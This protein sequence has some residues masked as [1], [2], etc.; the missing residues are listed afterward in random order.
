M[1]EIFPITVDDLIFDYLV[2]VNY[3][4][5]KNMEM[6]IFLAR[7]MVGMSPYSYIHEDCKYGECDPIERVT[8]DLTLGR[9]C[10]TYECTII[11]QVLA[12]VAP[13]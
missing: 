12:D 8:I 4:T 1:R 2:T 11:V 13:G 10:F 9:D 5:H 6:A 7:E 3:R